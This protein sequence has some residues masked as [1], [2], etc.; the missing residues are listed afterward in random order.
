MGIY[1]F[2]LCGRRFLEVGIKCVVHVLEDA[3]HL[4]GLC[5]IGSSEWCLY[6]LQ[7]TVAL[8][9]R[10][11]SRCCCQGLL[12]LRLDLDNQRWLVICHELIMICALR[13]TLVS[14]DR[15]KH[16]DCLVHLGHGRLQVCLQKV[17]S[18]LFLTSN[19]NGCRL[20]I[21]CCCDVCHKLR[22]FC[23]QLAVFCLKLFNAACE[24]SNFLCLLVNGSCLFLVILVAVA[25]VLR[26]KLSIRITINF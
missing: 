6:E 18:I 2:L 26:I 23:T 7:H 16:L 5:G 19:A 10:D 11:E 15:C 17:V 25:L 12:H 3:Y 1:R 21:F 9:V 4:H 20:P 13:Q 24:Q 14:T 22:T 8:L